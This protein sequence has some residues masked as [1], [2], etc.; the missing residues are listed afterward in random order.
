MEPLVEFAPDL[1][2][3]APGVLLDVTDLIPT[4]RGYKGRQAPVS[5]GYPAL[6][7]AANTLA[8]ATKLD[9]SRRIFAGTSAALY[10]ASGGAWIDRSDTGGYSIGVN[11]WGIAQFG[12]TTLAAAKAATL[13]ASTS[14]AFAAVSGAPKASLI[15]TSSG[16]VMLADTNEALYGDQS[17]RWYCSAYLDHT[18]WTPSVSSQCT[19]GR[20]IDAP[21]P[22]TALKALGSGFVAYKATAMW[23]G[24][25]VGA[26][27]VWQWTQVPGETGCAMPNG[28]VSMGSAHAFIGRDNLY[29]FD[30]ARPIPIGDKIREWFFSQLNNT[31]AY[32]TIGAYDPI[33][34]N[35]WWF[36]VSTNAAGT[37]PDRAL[38]F[39][40]ATGRFGR[41]QLDVEAAALYFQP[42]LTFDTIGSVYATWDALPTD[43][44]YD[45]PAWIA[46]RP[47]MAVINTAH[48]LQTLTGESA[49]SSLLTGNF[50]DDD[51]FQTCRGVRPR[52]LREPKTAQMEHLY[53]DLYGD[54]FTARDPVGLYEGKWDTLWSS[55]WHRF[56]LSFTGD[57]EINGIRPY[58][59]QDGDA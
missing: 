28:V 49:S 13:Q 4:A 46:A 21:G 38:V 36:Y 53:D 34:G 18:L 6:A 32:R 26:P 23:V 40:V 2:P 33:A 15:D 39:N 17:D 43:L 50:G 11:R 37:T 58:L 42:G 14:G 3:T 56:R 1:P 51:V 54:V 47:D 5:G 55:R 52:F 59:V 9:G 35:V 48:T 8:V 57:V 27:E 30:G 24:S 45:S 29:V 44:A 25:Y 16:F 31:Y 22:I 20:L 19:T 10:E 41:A 12:N 7:A